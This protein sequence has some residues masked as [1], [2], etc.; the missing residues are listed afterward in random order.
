MGVM[1]VGSLERNGR[2]VTLTGHVCVVVVVVVVGGLVYI[3]ETVVESVCDS[4]IDV[5]VDSSVGMVVIVGQEVIAVG[6]GVGC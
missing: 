6:S 3:G 2:V 4:G 5:V 1:G